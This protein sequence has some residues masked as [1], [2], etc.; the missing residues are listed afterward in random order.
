MPTSHAVRLLA[1]TALGVAA[2][3]LLF[4][5]RF[6]G[7]AMLLRLLRR[8]GRDSG[9]Q[10]RTEIAVAAAYHELLPADARAETLDHRTW[11]DLDLDEVFLSLDHTAS[12][13]G[14]QY[15]YHLLRAPHGTHAPLERLE[16]AVR[17]I[18]SAQDVAERLRTSLGRLADPRAGQL[19]HLLLGELPS[20]PRLWWL[21]PLL[22]AGAVACLMLSAVWPRALVVWLGIAV[23]NV[24]VQLFYKPRV[25]RF[26]PALHELPAFIGVARALGA[27]DLREVEAERRLLEGGASRLWS[28]HRA[29]AWLMFEPGETN[30]VAASLYEYVNLFFLLDVNAFVFTIERLRASQGLMREMFEAIGYLD[31]AQ[32]IGAWRRTLPRWSTPELIG[33]RKSMHIE[34]LVH[35]LLTQPVQNALQVEDAGVL[36]TGSN[37][38]GKTTFIRAVGVSAVLAQTLHTV[39]ANAWRAPMLRVRTSIGRTDSIM[40]GKSY[41]LAEVESVRALVRAKESSR[42]HLFLLDEIFRGTNTTERVAAASAVL[43]YLNRGAD[44]VLVATHDIDV[45]DLLGDSYVAYHFREQVDGKALTFDYHLHPG[46]SSSRNA[47]AL[48]Q[49]M[50]YPEELVAD[51]LAAV[52]WHG[53]RLSQRDA[54][55]QSLLPP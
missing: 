1:A 51:A 53:R 8:T 55:Y 30:D 25:K 54:Q 46:P 32:S 42:Q 21:F 28:L 18:A 14:R 16:R 2:F 35:P 41:Y 33:A 17:Q 31:A 13:P 6:P 4:S 22:T 52:G 5:R 26:V 40:E 15:L 49:L 47:I 20:R 7:V 50:E 3:A 19:V 34:G 11:K 39:C 27:L 24:G 10:R 36:I 37:M 45:M 23:V 38:S 12:E 44:F 43:A 29:T 48:L 9:R